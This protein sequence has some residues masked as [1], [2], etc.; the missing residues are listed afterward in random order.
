M[1][2]H[3]LKMNYLEA[4]G[5]G[6]EEGPRFTLLAGEANSEVLMELNYTEGVAPDGDYLV[7]EVIATDTNGVYVRPGD[8]IVV[9][10]RTISVVTSPSDELTEALIAK[11]EKVPDGTV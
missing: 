7:V 1:I 3:I 11:V 10:D 4:T 5:D 6:Y 9:S 2:T 8:L